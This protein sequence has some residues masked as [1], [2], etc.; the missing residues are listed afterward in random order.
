M[1]T[2]K[3]DLIKILQFIECNPGSAF[4]YSPNIYKK[5]T[6]YLFTRPLRE[7]AAFSKKDFYDILDLLDKE[8]DHTAFGYITYEA[9][10]LLEEKFSNLADKNSNV[11]FAKFYLF[12]QKNVRKLL[13]EDISFE[14]LSLNEYRKNFYLTDFSL[15]TN[16]E[17][18]TE[19]I[20]KIRNYI[21]EGETYQVNYTVKCKFTFH[22]DIISFF[23]LLLFNQSARYIAFINDGENFIVSFSPEL[24]FEKNK[25]NLYCK[26]MKGTQARGFNDKT[27]RM[28]SKKLFTSTK[29]HAENVMIVDL[30]RNDMGKISEFGS[31]EVQRLFEVEKY[32]SLFQMTSTISSSLNSN[33]RF[34]DIIKNLFPCGSITGAPKIRTMQIINELEKDKRGIYTGAIG[35]LDKDKMIFNVPIRTI[36]ISKD[37]G[38]GEVGIGSGI[39]WDSSSEGEYNETLLKS[40]FLLKT[41]A[42]FNIFT[43]MLVKNNQVFLLNRHIE[44][45]KKTADYFLFKFDEK[46]IKRKINDLL[47]SLDPFQC[48]RLKII[49][50]KW[51]NISHEQSIFYKNI[52]TST[53]II[54]SNERIS[55]LNKFQYF[56][57]TNRKLYDLELKNAL[58]AGYGEVLFLNEYE[59]LAEGAI[60]NV[61]IKKGNNWLTPP[62]DTGILDGIYRSYL[63]SS[64]R[65]YFEAELKLDDLLSAKEIIITNALRGVSKVRNIKLK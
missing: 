5:E 9:G 4:F 52:N 41:D 62:I 65:N 12:D 1:H 59:N 14:S 21:S 49:L 56:K 27:D 11:P 61:F 25:K 38:K 7:I 19:N 22:G 30:L 24:F 60:S 42:P 2:E 18:F 45:L 20:T 29:D 17:L 8:K 50:D 16:K 13:P 63:L 10:Y 57:T 54:I 31:V 48:Y 51:G 64:H 58:N 40:N 6:S 3:T 34:S 33:V 35:I 46:L 44:R 55:S 26:P 39:V 53:D 43:T 37:S 32:E 36:V 28:G 15:N 47:H 23:H